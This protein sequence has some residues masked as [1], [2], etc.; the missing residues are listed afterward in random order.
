MNF[1]SHNTELGLVKN[2][3]KALGKLKEVDAESG[4]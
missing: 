3:I 1:K 2:T 4:K